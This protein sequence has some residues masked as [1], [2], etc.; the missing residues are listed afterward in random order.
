MFVGFRT[1]LICMIFIT[2]WRGIP[3]F[4]IHPISRP[5]KG[6]SWIPYEQAAAL[7]LYQSRLALLW[8][9]YTLSHWG[10]PT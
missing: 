2:N 6:Y 1:E 7:P 8:Y 5:Q 4:H 3:S 10:Q 9:T